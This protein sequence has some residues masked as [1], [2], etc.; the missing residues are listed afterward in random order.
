[1]RSSPS[2]TSLGFHGDSLPCWSCHPGSPLCYN[3]NLIVIGGDPLFN[4]LPWRLDWPEGFVLF[5]N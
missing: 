2:E 4:V 3:Y 1:M 5:E